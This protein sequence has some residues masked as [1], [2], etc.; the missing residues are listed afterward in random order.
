MAGDR[1]IGA[2]PVALAGLIELRGIGIVELPYLED[3]VI[4]LVIDLD[5]TGKIER[6][7]EERSC[8]IFGLR[9]PLT[10]VAPFEASAPLKVEMMV[11]AIGRKLA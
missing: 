6:L 10:V 5:D 2:P 3:A 11:T 7:P 4:D 9:L 8:E 1:L